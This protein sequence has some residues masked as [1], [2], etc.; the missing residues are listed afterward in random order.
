MPDHGFVDGGGLRAAPVSHSLGRRGLLLGAAA[1]ALS[2][3]TAAPA[4][5]APPAP[6]TR[7]P[8]PATTAPVPTPTPT[9]TPTPSPTPALPGRADIVSRYAGRPATQW[10]WEVDGVVNR[11]DDPHSPDADA[12][13]VALTFD[14]CGGGT[15]GNGYDEALIDTLRRHGVTATLYLNARWIAANPTLAAELADDPLFVLASHGTRHVPLSVA[16]R[17]AYGIAGTADVGEVY[18]E[19]T[20]GFDWFAEHT[21]ALPATMRPGTAHC[22]EVAAAIAIDLGVPIAGLS[23]NADDG[24]TLGASG[25]AQRLASVR[26]G[27]IVLGHFN[28]PAGGTAEGLA[29]ALPRLLG[30][31]TTFV[32][33]GTRGRPAP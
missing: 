18:D 26:P 32:G 31:G 12:T 5:P 24:A 8:G 1:A 33:L 21:G 19:V 10:G 13:G 27:D 9:P 30:A 16:G 15:A 17:S 25:V 20:A 14:A 28:R 11:L 4:P 3:C 23:V 6:P 7:T 29:Q 22:D 2:A